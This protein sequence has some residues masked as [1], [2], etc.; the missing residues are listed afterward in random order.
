VKH[1][2]LPWLAIL[3]LLLMVI[4][5]MEFFK[6]IQGMPNASLYLAAPLMVIGIY[7]IYRGKKT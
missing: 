4:G 5:I 3:G 1:T 2:E 6:V 7:L